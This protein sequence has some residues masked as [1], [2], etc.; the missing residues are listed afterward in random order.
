MPGAIARKVIAGLGGIAVLAAAITATPP[1]RADD[2]ATH[3]GVASCAGSNCHGATQRQD[4]SSVQQNEYITWSTRD[5][6]RLAY[7][8]LLEDRAI[9]MAQALGLP[10]AKSAPVCLECH[11]DYVTPDQRGREFQ[12]SDGVGCEACHGGASNWLGVH[13]SGVG[14]QQNLA[15]GL[16]PTEK[17][18]ARAELCLNCHFGDGKRFVDH[19]LY[20]AGHPRLS[21]ELDT[22]TAAEP[23]HFLVDK[24]YL[25]RKG[26]ITDMQ[27]WAT[28]QAVTVIRRMQALLDP[29]HNHQGI[30]PQ[31]ALFD[32]TSCHHPYDP[33]HPRPN[34]AG[35]EPGLV[36]LDDASALMLC[37]AAGGLAPGA[38]AAVQDTN[39]A[40]DH[41]TMAAWPAVEHHAHALEHIA[42]ELTPRLAAHDFTAEDMRG[43][44]GALIAL[45]LA[46][47]DYQ[48]GRAEQITMGLEAVV[49]AMQSSGL[50][51][52]EQA[53]RI[54]GAMSGLYESLANPT[55]FQP[56]PFLKALH[57]VKEAFGGCC[58]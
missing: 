3:L 8:V 47:G 15:A 12:L 50:I 44:A 43:V 19:R 34:P 9:R 18:I 6:H 26:L 24:G 32:C 46:A 22:F 57:G 20:G 16:Y 25:Q 1:A 13:I 54:R 28:G 36:K 5:K 31:P 33:F 58:R 53:Q 2:R 7:K 29:S 37:I 45:G 4:G 35:L 55:A 40:L 21:F 39:A 38:A 52:S 17:P 56:D 42:A 10:D 41:A 49:G 11:A 48:Y 14:H 30:F 51:G 27:V 23:A